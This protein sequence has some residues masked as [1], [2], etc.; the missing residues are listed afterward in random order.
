M[1]ASEWEFID[2]HRSPKVRLGSTFCAWTAWT[3]DTAVLCHS[4]PGIGSGLNPV[5]IMH[6]RRLRGQ[7]GFSIASLMFSVLC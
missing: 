3:S 2:R 7:V 6:A 5:L 4:S 1:S